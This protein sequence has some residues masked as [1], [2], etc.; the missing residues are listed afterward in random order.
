MNPAPETGYIQVD[1]GGARWVRGP[2]IG[3]APWKLYVNG[4]ELLSFLCTP[5]DLHH[6]A[7]GFLHSEGLMK[8]LDDLVSLK[9][10]LD[11]HRCHWLVPALGLNATLT[12]GV[13]EESVGA[14]DVRL[15]GD[16][17]A[18]LGPQI[19]TTGCAGGVTF[20][21]LLAAHAPLTSE[22][23]VTVEQIRE[24][25]RQLSQSSELY[26]RCRGVHASALAEGDRLLVVAEDVGRHNTLD[27]IR[28]RCLLEDIPTAHR[29]LL[30]TGRI[31]SEMITKA[32]KMGVPVVVSRTSPTALSVRLARA[33]GMTLIGYARGRRMNVYAGHERVHIQAE[34]RD[35]AFDPAHDLDGDG[36]VS[37]R[38]VQL[39]A[40]VWGESSQ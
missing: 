26:R 23:T 40:R 13:A 15:R 30:S 31:S 18:G 28:G 7:L 24:L 36:A 11:E 38:D 3:E 5:T 8:S 4:R 6:L 37:A 32:V 39:A 10:Y 22:T 20:D 34:W 25:M 35:P 14:I 9:V 2:V 16:P 17:L 29:I 33:W 12:M 27:K 1:E 21:D 19:L